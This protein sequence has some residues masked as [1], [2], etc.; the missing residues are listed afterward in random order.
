[1]RE[2]G[3]EIEEISP[4]W[5]RQVNDDW[6]DLW[7]VFMSAFFGE[8]LEPYRDRM[9]PV[10]V[11]MIEKGNAMGAT[12]YKRVEILRTAMWK[13]M[14]R[15]LSAREAFLCPTCAVPAPPVTETDDD[16]VLTL[17]SGRFAGLDMTCP[18]NLLPQ[19]PA[20]SVPV[21]PVSGG[22][23]VGLQIIGHRF[24]DEAVLSIGGAIERL[25]G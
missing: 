17:D 3:A 2:A 8:R 4:C 20:L 14:T 16:Y 18:F 12:P 5:T 25:E 10:V 24:A 15:I 19:L 22:L 21:R 13:D 11:A 7:C 1:M 23:P 6:F 9:D